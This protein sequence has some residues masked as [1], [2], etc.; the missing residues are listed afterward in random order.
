[1]ARSE[2]SEACLE[3]PG[4]KNYHLDLPPRKVANSSLLGS[5]PRI[6]PSLSQEDE[7]L[8]V[9]MMFRNPKPLRNN[10][11]SKFSY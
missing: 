6:L 8:S 10:S 1:M 11:S 4:Y 3:G 5:I 9:I 2:V 7:L